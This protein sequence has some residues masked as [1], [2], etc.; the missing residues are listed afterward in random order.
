[1]NDLSDTVTQTYIRLAL[2][3]ERH[4]PGYVDAYFGP[5]E[6][7]RQVE[8]EALPSPAELIPEVDTLAT[9]I[10]ADTAMPAERKDFLSRQLRAMQTSLRLLDGEPLS[11]IEEVEAVYDITPGWIDEAV[12]E[13]AQR[14]LDD[15]LPPGDS[16]VERLA[17][18]KQLTEVAV[19]PGSPLLQE[20]M[21][22]LR[23]RTQARFPLPEEESFEIAFVKDEPWGAYNWYLGNF[24]SRI[25]INTDV[26][27]NISRLVDLIAHEAYPGHHTELAIKEAELVGKQGWLEHTIVLINSP[28]CV[29]AEGIATRALST[30]M[31]EE[32]LLAWNTTELF[33]RAGLSQL[34]AK[35]EQAIETARLALAGVPSNATFLMFD[36][37]ADEAEVMA[38]IQRYGL[39]TEKEARRTV[40]F[41]NYARSYTF[42]YHYGGKLLDT[43]FAAWPL[44]RDTWFKR[45]LSEPVTP[46]QVRAWIDSGGRGTV[47]SI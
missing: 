36:Q 2:A 15:L 32:E 1:M 8:A 47:E 45:L 13:E 20:I 18:R 33:P 31:T 34:D 40:N 19:E 10:A 35:R 26:P 28:S 29:I 3:I 43:L 16:L 6:W 30:L 44:A 25:D 41:L 14:R 23:R 46:G 4:Q 11:L 39:G 12:F 42:T 5:A 37:G 21:A 38:Y 9:D 7:R 24:R 22:E 17:Q 27:T